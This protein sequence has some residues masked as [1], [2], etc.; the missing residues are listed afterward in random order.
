MGE[1]A[2]EAGLEEDGGAAG[3]EELGVFDVSVI[4]FARVCV[5]ECWC[6]PLALP[7]VSAVSRRGVDVCACVC[8]FTGVAAHTTAYRHR[9][10]MC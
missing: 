2:T 1:V 3:L 7:C 6:E 9:D 4:V 5:C 10:N 8:V